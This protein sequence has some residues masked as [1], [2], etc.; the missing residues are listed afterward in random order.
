M[1]ARTLRP[2]YAKTELTAVQLISLHLCLHRPHED[3]RS[4]DVHFA[5]Y[6]DV[7]PREFDSHPLTWLV[8]RTLSSGG[9]G[10]VLEYDLLSM[11][12]PSVDVALKQIEARFED[13]W[14][15]VETHVQSV[16]KLLVPMMY[17]VEP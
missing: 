9:P 4:T 16:W 13:D 3:G 14:K 15:A 10:N 11:L 2:L 17:P 8:N 1:N 12:P 7:L 5:P 6:I